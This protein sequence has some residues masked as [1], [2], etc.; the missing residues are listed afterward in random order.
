MTK[1]IEILVK[2][3]PFLEVI[4]GRTIRRKGDTTWENAENASN[5]FN[6]SSTFHIL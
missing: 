6:I 1:E 5:A 2:R 3:G 4:S